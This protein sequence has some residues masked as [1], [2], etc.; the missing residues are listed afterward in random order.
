M[1]K[2]SDPD[3][4]QLYRILIRPGQ[5]FRNRPSSG[6]GRV[7]DPTEF[8]IRLCSGSGCAP[9]PAVLRIHNTAAGSGSEV[10]LCRYI[11]AGGG[12]TIMMG[13]R[14]EDRV[15]CPLPLYHSVGGM[16]SLSGRFN[17]ILL[18]VP[19]LQCGGSEF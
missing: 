18:F 15:Y 11:L 1:S 17:L 19:L 7:P 6:S 8:R 9:D 10:N 16:I 14:Q 3:P 4:V 5:K 2:S 13:V 12:L